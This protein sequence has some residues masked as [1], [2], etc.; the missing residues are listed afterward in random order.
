MES[1]HFVTSLVTTIIGL[2]LVS[3]ATAALAKRLRI[4][5][6]VLLIMV[7]MALTV[8]AEHGPKF[9]HPILNYDISPEVILFVFLPTLIFESAFNLDS[10][11]LRRNILPVLTLAGP[12]LL[13]STA[14]IGY[15][16]HY[17]TGLDLAVALLLG[18]I[19]SATDPVA[20]ISIFKKLG[21]PARLNV[22]VEG[23][24][25]FNDAT[26]IVVARML[27]G[28]VAAGY[29]SPGAAWTGLLD[30]VVVFGG[31]V[32]V[33][34]LAGLCAG[35]VLGRVRSDSFI[36]ISL[37][38][39]LA[40]FS[41]LLAEELFQVSGVMATVAAGVTLGG[42][43]RTKISP[44]VTEYLENFWSYMA[45]IA[46][47]LIFLL[48]GLRVDLNALAASFDL[49]IWVL[50]AML[51][52]RAVVIFGLLPLSSRL[53]GVEKVSRPFQTVMWWG[54]L[55]GAI[56]L[57]IVLSLENMPN[58]DT[59]IA[60]V[61]GAVLFTLLV[62]GLTIEKL[63]RFLALDQLSPTDRFAKIEGLLHAKTHAQEMIPGLQA[64]GLFS[65]RIAA[66]L[67]ESCAVEAENLQTS[68]KMLRNEFFDQAQEV[69]LLTRRCFR[70]EKKYYYE[71][72]SKSHLSER[73]Y[74][75]LCHSLELQ[76][77]AVRAD[78]PIPRNT[79][80]P[81]SGS[82]T[83]RFLT[84]PLA[85]L[86]LINQLTEEWRMEL[87]SREYEEAWGRYQG[88]CKIL[89]KLEHLDEFEAVQT[90]MTEELQGHYHYWRDSAKKRLDH[91]ADQFPE[92]VNAMQV[93][94][95][96]R[97]LA[98]AQ[99]S[100]IVE[101]SR[102][103]SIPSG[104]AEALIEELNARI[105]VLRGRDLDTLHI[106]ATE[107]LRKVPFFRPIP[108]LEFD[109]VAVRLHALTLTEDQIVIRQGGKG[110]SL[111]L[112]GR[113]VIRVSRTENGRE[114]DLA[115]LLAGDFF[116]EMALLHNEPRTATCRTVTPCLIYELKSVDLNE[117]QK[118]CPGLKAALEEADRQ[119][120]ADRAEKEAG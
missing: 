62:Q 31:G 105:W 98:Q 3:A 11:Q 12:G 19:L 90:K 28:V 115:T 45:Q 102:A 81:L 21:A 61:M 56:A 23:E 55:R 17:G 30:F 75:D 78:L 4:P 96:G 54:G 53:P 88:S 104:I 32:V 86:P 10:L 57:A 120:S 48:V 41:F 83:S 40:Y 119:R 94:L 33:G 72:F 39:I 8:L 114:K 101:E 14:I 5:F 66:T 117:L 59:L 43:G 116:G 112:I 100:I 97:L 67:N 65:Q 44:S 60:I 1:S 42:W 71:L 38:T 111:F 24:S 74:R 20:V 80:H 15:I 76:N 47:A 64:G 68:L 7:G 69:K 52:S 2:L 107:V 118:D 73:S 70:L 9:L 18:S 89:A 108:P 77:E 103:G 110:D 58:G 29:F 35:M 63:V 34:W 6:T 51:I 93:R 91:T 37:T 99:Q 92:F 50:A 49:L 46:N 95:A 79:I 27:T 82:L 113:G 106:K 87:I 25:L 22:L 36:E 26:S 109:R 85:R 84:S 16:L 13:L